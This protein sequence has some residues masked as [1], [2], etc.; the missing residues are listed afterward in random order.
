MA[1][2]TPDGGLHRLSC[3]DP[4]KVVRDWFAKEVRAIDPNVK[5]FVDKMGSQWAIFPGENND[6]PPIA[7]GSHLDS[8]QTGGRYDGPL[9]VWTNEE[10][11]RFPPACMASSVWAGQLSLEDAHR[12]T[13]TVNRS[14]TIGDELK[15]IGYAGEVE[16]SHRTNPLSAHFEIH[17]EQG[18][19]L[20]KAGKEVGIVDSSQ[21]M[22]WY[23]VSLRGFTRHTDTTFMEDRR[24]ALAG[25][26]KCVVEIQRVGR[27]S[28]TGMA[29]VS[30]FKSSPQNFCNIPDKVDFSFSAQHTNLA[31]LRK[32]EEGILAFI[33][34]TAQEDK[35]E[36][37]T[38][39]KIWDLE[40]NR[41]DETAV[42]C[43][44][45]AA[46][47]M[48][49]NYTRIGNMTGHD[50]S[51]TRLVC[52]TAMVFTPC[53]DG[54]SHNPAEYASPEECSTGAQVILGGVLNFDALLRKKLSA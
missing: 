34:N 28:K 45:D 19:R 40:P 48:G 18:S 7:V 21:G 12:C 53:K 32:M 37:V 54:I 11:A 51:Y 15:R 8:V 47:E 35:L 9:G 27:E 38:L 4:D 13:D 42:Q 49:F 10:G 6:I 52:P 43:L 41:F 50:S 3:S 24:D 16:A 25:A 33:R 1:G 29:T 17:I 39:E 2:A 46:K 22:V 30:L 31:V 14:I 20:E 23:N 44:E 5:Y 36:V 26:A